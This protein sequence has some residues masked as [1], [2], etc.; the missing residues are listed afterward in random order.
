MA[1]RLHVHFGA[2]PSSLDQQMKSIGRLMPAGKRRDLRVLVQAEKMMQHPKLSR[3]VDLGS[4]QIAHAQLL[5]YLETVNLADRRKGHV[6]GVLG[7]IAF[8]LLLFIAI[9]IGFL[10]WRDLI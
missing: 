6:L 7:S 3:Q 10:W 8:N 1:H 9:L 5:P 2:K 4:V